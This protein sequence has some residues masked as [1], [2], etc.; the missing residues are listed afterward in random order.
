MNRAVPVVAL[1]VV[2][3]GAA[4]FVL[5]PAPRST[6][7]VEDGATDADTDETKG[8]SELATG[9]ASAHAI[10]AK[11]SKPT[12]GSQVTGTVRRGGVAVAARVEAHYLMPADGN[13][14]GRKGGTGYFQRMM[15]PPPSEKDAAATTRAGDDG[16]FAIDGLGAGVYELRAETDDGA[17]GWGS[18]TIPID[19]A[20]VE[21]NVDV[22][23]GSETLS[24]RVI[25]TDGTP[26]TGQVF[27]DTW[28]G[29]QGGDRMGALGAPVSSPTDATGAFEA[30]GLKAGE[31]MV[32]AVEPGVF[33]V[34]SVAIKIPRAEPFVLIV[35][36]ALSTT[37]GRVVADADGSPLAGAT[38]AAGGQGGDFS[39]FIAQTTTG[40]DGAF[41]IRIPAGNQSGFMISAEGY[42]PQ[43]RQ[44]REF[45]AGEPIEFRMIQAARVVGLVTRASD[46]T[47]VALASVRVLSLDERNFM[48][49]TETA[50]T[51]ADGRYEQD[52]AASG[53]V[54]VTADAPGLVTKGVADVKGQGFNPLATT[55]RPGETTTVDVTMVAGAKVSGTVVDSVG[56]PVRGAVIAPVLMP[57]DPRS[58]SRFDRIFGEPKAVSGSDGSYVI[59]FLVP[60]RTYALTAD[61]A[62]HAICRADAFTASET[63]PAVVNLKFAPRRMAEIT[64][65]DDATGTGVAGARVSA[66]TAKGGGFGRAG[67]TGTT[68]ADGR[69]KLGPLEPGELRLDVQSEDY[70]R[71]IGGNSDSPKLLADETSAVVRLRRGLPI[72]GRVTM[73][74]KTPA[75]GAMVQIEYDGTTSRGW[76]QPVTT[77]ADGT[78]RLRGV[79]AGSV[80][81]TVN[82]SKDGKG[83][84]ASTAATVGAEDL[85]LALV[86]GAGQGGAKGQLV[87]RV[88]DAEGKAVP[89]ASA[90]IRSKGSTSSTIVTNGRV[91]LGMVAGEAATI[92]IWAAKGRDGAA[93]N[94]APF[95]REI[96]GKE[97]EI[98]VKL[99]SGLSIEGVVHGSDGVGIRGVQVSALP[100]PKATGDSDPYG[101]MGGFG[102]HATART[103]AT[104]AFRLNGLGDDEYTLSVE[105]AAEFAPYDGPSVRAGVKGVDVS[106]KSGVAAVI[107]VLDAAGKPI[108]G[109][110][111]NAQVANADDRRRGSRNSAWSKGA[112]T[113][114]TGTAR[115]AGLATGVTYRLD[116]QVAEY[117]GF[118]QSPWA[119]ADTTV[120]LE[121]AFT[122]SGIVK[123]KAGKPVAR[124]NVQWTKDRAGGSWSG[125]QA[126]EDGRFTLTGLGAGEVYL[127]AVI[128]WN[129]QPDAAKDEPVRALA[130]AKDVV[131]IVDV[132]IDLVV[133]IENWP[134]DAPA[135][136]TPM[137][138]VEGDNAR[139]L[140]NEDMRISPDGV[141]RFRG[142]RE[143]ETYALWIP[144]IPGGL[145]CLATGLKTGG[146]EVRVRMTP[147]KSVTGR[148][149][150]PAGADNVQ[151][152]VNATGISTSGKVDADG[153]F[154]IEGLPD[155]A[156]DVHGHAQKDGVWWYATGKVSAGGSLNL[157][158]KK[159]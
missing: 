64:V 99:S 86:E 52:N 134:A 139:Q 123:D 19:G 130:G 111:V 126:N 91:T 24:G 34:S 61:C 141:M 107:T 95:R 56:A 102:N 50:T 118:S 125:N 142:L 159:P 151:V 38:V 55:V 96:D 88:L 44:M 53:E 43:S 121:R 101:S 12:G 46:A 109:A 59:D 32:S 11:A 77:G 26:W 48:S 15:S 144:A 70:V 45:K 127:R 66:A 3:A 104:G 138:T 68:G 25:R 40:A 145:S 133:K 117:V 14:F 108:P 63:V 103:D 94:L 5:N 17:R 83:Y 128:G 35:D 149:T 131:L 112:P 13:P 132:G 106:L 30:K 47:P 120:R 148:I 113:D 78:F 72:A 57:Y 110:T 49:S 93:L 67:T 81:L 140:G 152:S 51:H 157:E 97:T 60:G 154:T 92:T 2:A 9:P 58:G 69:V 62:G 31:V 114:A 85:V 98:E 39:V 150:A 84:S 28:R 76:V 79:L 37:K 156:Y 23:G 115:L 65:L 8:A 89:S 155:G 41:E 146:A 36:A 74:D 87:V 27:V 16:R 22:D 33:R 143:S 158:L 105:A 122:V 129:F 153:R 71:S 100:K 20:F 116:V 4:W 124:A 6:V 42:A 90:M 1:L 18:A 80:K 7:T 147:G 137:L 75:V 21:A 136:H 73:P 29:R 82:L 54:M 10:R 135:W 119:P